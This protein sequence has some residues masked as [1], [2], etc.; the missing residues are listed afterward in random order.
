M[1]GKDKS[2]NA[3]GESNKPQ[4]VGGH[5]EGG[6]DQQ[7]VSSSSA[8]SSAGSSSSGTGVT[9]NDTGNGATN[10]FTNLQL[11]Q[12]A[13]MVN[14]ILDQRNQLPNNPLGGFNQPPNP[15]MGTTQTNFQA[16]GST[17][18]DSHAS[19]AVST[20]TLA[21]L[22][23]APNTQ[24]SSTAPSGPSYAAALG[25]SS[26]S[27]SPSTV[28]LNSTVGLFGHPDKVASILPALKPL[29]KNADFDIFDE[30]QTQAKRDMTNTGGMLDIVLKP[31]L[32]NRQ[33][34]PLYLLYF[35]SC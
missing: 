9:T 17:Q 12:L 19:S 20:G 35:I 18:F 6:D 1:S 15:V 24:N 3:G 29:P 14:S 34:H 11:Q 26:S 10:G 13:Q 7:T 23:T 2:T 21:S 32:N 4:R 16:G 27:S 8:S 33:Q 25:S 5:G 30:W 22:W 31:M 28:V